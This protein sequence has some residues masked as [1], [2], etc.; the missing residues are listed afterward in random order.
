MNRKNSQ[1]HRVVPK[2]PDKK[3]NYEYKTLKDCEINDIVNIY[4]VV[5]DSTFPHKSFKSAK[6]LVTLKLAD[7]TSRWN[8]EGIVDFTSIVFFADK[9]EDLPCC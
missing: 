6:F 8:N 5:V 9:F 4:A 7:L 1:Q 3:R 2:K